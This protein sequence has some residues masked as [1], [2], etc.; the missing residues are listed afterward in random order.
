MIG[1]SGTVVVDETYIGGPKPGK[2]GR[3][4]AGKALVF[5]AVEDNGRHFGRIRLRRM[6]D[7]SGASLIP[8]VQESVEPG[9]TV[10]TDG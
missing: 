9:S 5:I 10:R 8:A 2:R 4:A 1:L 3:G 6:A 7:A